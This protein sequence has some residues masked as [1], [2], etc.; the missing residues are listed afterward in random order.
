MLS[1]SRKSEAVFRPRLV[2]SLNVYADCDIPSS[3][4]GMR[5]IL[6]ATVRQPRRGRR[7]KEQIRI[8]A[9]HRFA[10]YSQAR[11]HGH[12]LA[13]RGAPTHSP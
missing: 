7:P 2:V 4:P 5:A 13:M 6:F 3:P 8:G 11:L 12:M 1:R 10:V 9:V